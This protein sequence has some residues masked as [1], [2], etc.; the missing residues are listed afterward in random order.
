MELELLLKDPT[1]QN[2]SAF[3][4][5]QTRFAEDT[6]LVKWQIINF[7]ENHG[8]VVFFLF[9]YICYS[10]KQNLCTN[11]FKISF[12]LGICPLLLLIAIC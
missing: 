4:V 5:W 2:A 11:L 10:K 1:Y 6:L 7:E 3:D 12:R 9:V 8:N